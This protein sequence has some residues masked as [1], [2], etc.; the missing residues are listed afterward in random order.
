MY[1]KILKENL[2]GELNDRNENFISEADDK[3]K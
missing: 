1:W 3:I 2:I